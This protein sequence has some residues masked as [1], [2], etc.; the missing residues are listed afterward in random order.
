MGIL[1]FLT[2]FV[3]DFMLHHQIGD[4]MRAIVSLAVAEVVDGESKEIG[5]EAEVRQSRSP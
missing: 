4:R 1:I 5:N 2:G 3:C